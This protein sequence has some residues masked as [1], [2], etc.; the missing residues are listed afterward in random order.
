[1]FVVDRFNRLYK[2][3]NERRLSILMIVIVFIII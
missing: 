3:M 2:G 1:M